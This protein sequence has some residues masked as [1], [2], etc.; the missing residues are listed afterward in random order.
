MINNS[1]FDINNYKRVAIRKTLR[2][3]Q[4]PQEIILWSKLRNNQTGY[5]FRR[6]V[7]IGKYVVDFY[8]TE[9]KLVIE[10]D[11]IQHDDAKEYDE[12]RTHYLK[13]QGIDV[14]RFWNNE[15]NTI[16]EGVMVKILNTLQ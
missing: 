16:I 5:K 4:T 10:I 14:L 13:T 15:R 11:G 7:S 3:N 9:K 2:R 8:C 6:Q 1:S 12:I